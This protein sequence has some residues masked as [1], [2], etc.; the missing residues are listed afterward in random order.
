MGDLAAGLFGKTMINSVR[1]CQLTF[2]VALCHF[3]LRAAEN[4]SL[5]KLNK[6]IN[7]L[8]M[9]RHENI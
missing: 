2:N 5:S 8:L 7:K 4:R 6:E 3:T 9:E 1:N